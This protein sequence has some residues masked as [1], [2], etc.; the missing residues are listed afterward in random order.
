MLNAFWAQQLNTHLNNQMMTC[1][2]VQTLKNQSHGVRTSSDST[3]RGGEA[4][5]GWGAWRSRPNQTETKK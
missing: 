3:Q 2:A 4:K 1:L 5:E